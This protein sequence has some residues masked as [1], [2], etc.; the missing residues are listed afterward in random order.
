MALCSCCSGSS[1]SSSS[2]HSR[3]GCVWDVCC[4]LGGERDK[5]DDDG[6]AKR[7]RNAKTAPFL[8]WKMQMQLQQSWTHNISSLHLKTRFGAGDL[9]SAQ[10]LSLHT[11]SAFWLRS[12][13]VS[14]L[15]SLISNTESTALH[16]IKLIFD[17][18]PVTRCACT[19]AQTPV[20][21]VLHCI[22]ERQTHI[23]S[24][25][26]PS[27]LFLLHSLSL[28]RGWWP[29][30]FAVHL[31]ARTVTSCC[32]CCCRGAVDARGRLRG[33]YLRGRRGS[34]QAPPARHHSLRGQKL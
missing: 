32:C 23:L 27:C 24:P 18:G 22:R 16:D 1:S 21:P 17:R 29:R 28:C 12:S 26:S 7:R 8:S 33:W 2:K 6:A 25:N 4:L 3:Q 34:T 11:F 10:S 13:V 14:V 19:T 9:A 5:D 30:R 15:I 31:L 20:A